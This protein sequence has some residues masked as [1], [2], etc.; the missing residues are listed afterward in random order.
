MN[1]ML[2]ESDACFFH[3]CSRVLKCTER[4]AQV[5]LSDVFGTWNGSQ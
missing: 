5:I 4:K 1:R 2:I 3:T